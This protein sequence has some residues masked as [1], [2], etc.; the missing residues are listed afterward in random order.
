[1]ILADRHSCPVGHG[2]VT[3]TAFL[4]F[5]YYIS[6]FVLLRVHKGLWEDTTHRQIGFYLQRDQGLQSCSLFAAHRQ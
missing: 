6:V 3:C 5:L 1:M 4:N 2:N